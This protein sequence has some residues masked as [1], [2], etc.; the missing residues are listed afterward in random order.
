MSEGFSSAEDTEKLYVYGMDFNE[1]EFEL[2]KGADSVIMALPLYVDGVPS[3][4]I[5]FMNAYAKFNEKNDA[6]KPK[7]YFIIN[8]GFM[9]HEQ[10]NTAIKILRSF[11]EKSGFAFG[12][13]ISIGS[14]AMILGTDEAAK[15]KELLKKLAAEAEKQEDIKEALQINVNMPKEKFRVVF[16][17][18]WI[19]VAAKKGLTE[20]D[21]RSR[22]Y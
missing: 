5:E 12:G 14:G 2:I 9:E 7:F 15:V 16:N 22:Y 3:R 6:G 13:G 17:Q 10:N 19:D 4:V 18:V 1:E 21:L 8:C 11:S 20:E